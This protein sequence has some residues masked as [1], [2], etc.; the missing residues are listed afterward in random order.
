MQ[1]PNS[2]QDGKSRLAHTAPVMYIN[3][4]GFRVD[5]IKLQISYED[6]SQC[7]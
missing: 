1:V 2:G 4:N 7:I 6:S 3:K 5:A